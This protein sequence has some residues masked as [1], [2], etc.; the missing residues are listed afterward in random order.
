[1][2][3]PDAVSSEHLEAEPLVP[4][5]SDE[6][7]LRAHLGGDAQAFNELV[8]RHRLALWTLALRVLNDPDDAQDAVQVSLIYAF[9]RAHTYRGDAQVLTWLRSIV[10][11]TSKTVAATRTRLAQRAAEA[12]TADV[13]GPKPATAIE[14]EALHQVDLKAALERLPPDQ[15]RA[16]FLVRVH[17]FTLVEAA[18]REGV[19][20]GTIKS[21]VSRARAALA[22]QIVSSGDRWNL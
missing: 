9:R 19:P 15:R 14:D 6:A 7:L 20:L 21:R 12:A 2:A 11:N 4:A 18:R 16:F 10:E 17:G 22:E 1:M 8:R 3:T 13:G 5:A